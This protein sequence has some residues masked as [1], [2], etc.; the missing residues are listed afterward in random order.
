MSCDASSD[1]LLVA[2]GT[3]LQGNDASILYWYESHICIEDEGIQSEPGTFDIPW[4][5]SVDTMK[6]IQTILHP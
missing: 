3:A 1:G 4:H 2:A 5:L 6:R